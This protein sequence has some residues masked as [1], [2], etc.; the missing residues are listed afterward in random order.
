MTSTIALTL[1][2]SQRFYTLSR[3][4]VW[5]RQTGCIGYG[6]SLE[7]A[8]LSRSFF[9]FPC[10]FLWVDIWRGLASGLHSLQRCPIEDWSLSKGLEAFPPSMAR[11]S[12]ASSRLLRWEVE[13]ITPRNSS[14]FPKLVWTRAWGLRSPGHGLGL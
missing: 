12:S 10:S 13:S 14:Y 8:S 1:P 3:C 5:P 2:L 9:L 7:P 6:R 11:L 4:A